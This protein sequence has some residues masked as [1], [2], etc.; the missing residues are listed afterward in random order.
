MGVGEFGVPGVHVPPRVVV[1]ECVLRRE[2]VTIQCRFVVVKNVIRMAQVILNLRRA[3][4]HLFVPVSSLLF[5]IHVKS[6]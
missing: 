4:L 2:F 6:V 1:A 3:R 5:C